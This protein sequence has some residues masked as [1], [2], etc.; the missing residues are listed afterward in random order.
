MGKLK[1]IKSI[2][3]SIA[4]EANDVGARI[5]ELR[6]LVDGWLDGSGIAPS[7]DGL[8]WFSSV[9][10]EEYP[11]DLPRPYLYPTPE[12]NLLAEWSLGAN[13][14]SLEVCLTSHQAE[15]HNLNLKSNHEITQSLNLDEPECWHELER[16]LHPLEA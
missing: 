8:D 4:R 16:L 9:F 2:E 14:S 15:F 3:P 6:R 10:E 13:S 11:T 7:S 5:D 1:D 12:G